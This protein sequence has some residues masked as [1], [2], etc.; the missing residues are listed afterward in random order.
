MDELIDMDELMAELTLM[1]RV[2][3]VMER[4]TE[5]EFEA[6]CEWA[7]RTLAEPDA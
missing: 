1:C 7:V 5:E 3:T 6:V 2:A 4:L